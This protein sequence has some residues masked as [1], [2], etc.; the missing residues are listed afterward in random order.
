MDT[1][2]K[3]LEVVEPPRELCQ[4]PEGRSVRHVT[5][6]LPKGANYRA[7]DH[8]ETWKNL[9]K[10]REVGVTIRVYEVF[11]CIYAFLELR[12]LKVKCFSTMQWQLYN[13]LFFNIHRYGTRG[14]QVPSSQLHLFPQN[15]SMSERQKQTVS[16]FDMF[17]ILLLIMVE[18][19]L[20]REH[21]HACCIL[22]TEY[23]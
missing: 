23:I 9:P 2:L 22:N 17:L 8:L 19:D 10:S 4:K 1:Q 6:R 11:I 7:G 20:I 3:A 14:I 21:I 18:H 12:G 5:L 15:D 13:F 16:C